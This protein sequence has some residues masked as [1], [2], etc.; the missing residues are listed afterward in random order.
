MKRILGFQNRLNQK[1][2]KIYK[3]SILSFLGIT[4]LLIFLFNIIYSNKEY[5]WDFIFENENLYKN[6]NE[7]V[8]EKYLYDPLVLLVCGFGLVTSGY[9]LQSTNKNGLAGPSTL[10]LFPLA[11]LGSILA[12]IITKKFEQIYIGYVFGIVFSLVA[13]MFNYIFVK[14]AKTQKTFKPILFGFSLGAIITA[15]NILISN[16]HKDISASPIQLLG[17]VG[18]FSS[19]ERFYVA[20]PISL[21]SSIILLMISKSIQIID[22]NSN[23]ANTLGVN[24]NCIYWVSAICSAFIAISTVFLI[25]GLSLV[26]IIIPHLSRI[27]FRRTN[28]IF[29]LFSSLFISGI[30]LQSVGIIVEL[31][32]T[33]NI[34]FVVATILAIPMI[35]LVKYEVGWKNKGAN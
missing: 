25:G 30:L 10:G 34:I 21:I 12:S 24:V 27:L 17:S 9:A 19:I 18:V 14:N 26:A 5:I 20:V 1:Q 6:I 3:W 4:T 2:Y 8:F 11:A 13:L 7:K 33:I 35:F 22:Y 23:L 31:F 32:K 28:Y 16:L 29:Q 15:V